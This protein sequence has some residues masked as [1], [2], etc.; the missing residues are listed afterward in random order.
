MNSEYQERL[1]DLLSGPWSTKAEAARQRMKVLTDADHRLFRPYS[2]SSPI[3]DRSE[4][5]FRQSFDQALE[6][7]QLLELAVES[8]YLS[9]DA[10]RSTAEASF[11]E[12]LSLS[13]AKHYLLL[14]DYVLVRFLAARLG[15]EL[16]YGILD[17]PPVNDGAEL[18]FA[19]F[20]A[21]YRDF[22]S[23]EAIGKFTML[24]DDFKFQKLINVTFLK[25]VLA[26]TEVG[27]NAKQRQRLESLC[28][29]LTQFVQL[30]GD[31][32]LGLA[33]DQQAL[34]GMQFAY[35]LSHFFGMRHRDKAGLHPFLSFSDVVTSPVLFPA[36]L[37][38]VALATEQK[39]FQERIGVL[40]AVW[41]RTR[42][43]VAT[44]NEGSQ[45]VMRMKIVRAQDEF[46]QEGHASRNSG[47]TEPT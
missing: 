41:A 7:L 29:G 45:G 37:D 46:V 6:E 24:L 15:F 42:S 4:V 47:P 25:G 8:G 34:F 5:A 19:G 18:R 10:V 43:L 13:A 35:W 23:N 31:F 32:F 11:K 14:Y 44:A 3:T 1:D 36:G 40:H 16:D 28:L 12:L 20:L 30:L 26:G 38:S 27:L 22:M 39:R 17:V 21:V 33:D 9:L 2:L